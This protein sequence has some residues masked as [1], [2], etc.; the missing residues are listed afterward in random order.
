MSTFTQNRSITKTSLTKTK[1]AACPAW[2]PMQ[3]W[4]LLKATVVNLTKPVPATLRHFS[5][6]NNHP[7][8]CCAWGTENAC[9]WLSISDYCACQWAILPFGTEFG[10]GCFWNS[11]WNCSEGNTLKII[12]PQEIILS[13]NHIARVSIF[14][15]IFMNQCFTSYEAQLIWLVFSSSSLF[16][17]WYFWPQELFSL[18]KEVLS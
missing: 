15:N 18:G 10:T 16:P 6:S 5:G 4:Y 13:I 1:S 8:C 14:R 17:V 3:V 7:H 12:Q 2:Q 11:F 9:A